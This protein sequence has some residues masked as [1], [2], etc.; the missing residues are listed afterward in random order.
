MATR[1]Y[2]RP[3]IYGVR[4]NLSAWSK[5]VAAR[6][7]SRSVAPGA[8]TGVTARGVVEA[9]VVSWTAPT[10]RADGEDLPFGALAGY[11]VF[12][13]DEPSIDVSDPGTYDSVWFVNAETFTYALDGSSLGPWYFVVCAVDRAGNQGLPSTEV[14]DSGLIGPDDI[15][16]DDWSTGNAEAVIVGAGRIFLKMR[17]AKT[18]WA[19]FSYYKV[20]TDVNTGSGFPGSWSL[21]GTTTTGFMHSPLNTSYAYQYKVT[22]VA[23]DGT[24]TTGT[25]HNGAGSGYIPNEEDQD[26]L[27]ADT[28][29]AQHIIAQ[30]DIKGRTLIG[31]TLRS[32]NWGTSDGTEFNLDGGTFKLGGSS[33]PKL[34]WD[35]SELVTTGTHRSENY[36]EGED[37][38]AIFKNGNAEFYNIYIRGGTIE[39][40][41]IPSLGTV[42]ENVVDN[43]S[44]E[45]VSAGKPANWKTSGDWVVDD[46][47][48]YHGSRSMRCT[49]SGTLHSTWGP[50]N[51]GLDVKG[52]IAVKSDVAPTSPT[53]VGS[54]TGSGTG[55]SVVCVSSANGLFVGVGGS[56]PKLVSFDMRDPTNPTVRSSISLSYT[57]RHIWISGSTLGV[58]AGAELNLYTV[59]TDQTLTLY[60]TLDSRG[61]LFGTDVACGCYFSLFRREDYAIASWGNNGDGQLGD[62][63]TTN[64]SSPTRIGTCTWKAIDGGGYHSLGIRGDNRL[65]SWG[66]NGYGELGDGTYEDRLEPTLIGS[67]T[68]KAISAGDGYSLGIRA[69]DRLLAWGRNDYYQLG[70]GTT[71]YSTSPKLIGSC[72][73]KAVAA[74]SFHSLGIRADDRLLGWGYNESGQIGDGTTNNRTSPTLVGSCTWKSIAVGEYHSLGIRSDDRLLAWGNNYYYQLGDGTT[75]SQASPKL[76]GT[77]TW[78][79]IAAGYYH[80]MGIRGDGRLLAWGENGWGQLG[81]GTT[82]S[83]SSPQIIGSSTWK[84]IAGGGGHSIGIRSDDCIM[85]WGK[86][87][88]GELGDG[89]TIARYYPTLSLANALDPG[90][91]GLHTAILYGNCM[92]NCSDYQIVMRRTEDY[93]I[94]NRITLSGA[95]RPYSVVRS[96]NTLFVAARGSTHLF[97]INISDPLSA[98]ILQTVT[99]AAAATDIVVYGNHLY[100]QTASDVKVY[101]VSDPS[102]ITYVRAFGDASN[103][104][105]GLA[106]YGAYLYTCGVSSGNRVIKVYSLADPSS[107]SYVGTSGNQSNKMA[108]P[109]GYGG[110]LYLT[111]YDGTDL[112]PKGYAATLANAD[113]RLYGQFGTAATIGAATFTGS[114]LND[115]TSGGHYTGLESDPISYRVQIDG[116]GTPDTFKWS[117]DGGASWVATGVNIMG[118]AQHLEDGVVVTF[119]A[120][121]GH[122]VGDRWDFT[123]TPSQVL[124]TVQVYR[125]NRDSPLAVDTWQGAVRV[126]PAGSVSGAAQAMRAVVE[127]NVGASDKVWVDAVSL[128]NEV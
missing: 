87:S 4:S 93:S 121:T 48:A 112:A 67:C 1:G 13:S 114:G 128:R 75:I 117:N 30:Y 118:T 19:G 102:D 72:T 124:D 84:S 47:D 58:I 57:P 86:N 41:S 62:G 39:L 27:L 101:D 36:V 61:A 83:R 99:P 42:H 80:S 71:T 45:R 12:V 123:V 44:F 69:D 16:V 105:Y 97:S 107:P 10:V 3:H 56:A 26:N 20:Y 35:G 33:N 63:T 94:A 40:D 115:M 28:V 77:C 68:W 22:V 49:G 126:L 54:A 66:N 89:T 127:S 37:G 52:G 11:R 5:P 106:L 74:G 125:G 7:P 113:I 17:A 18:T 65:L 98:S 78:K 59:N 50:C 32:T 116:T 29:A 119:G 95:M 38:W 109:D 21:I 2:I 100:L 25:V 34:A 73:W 76:I 79:A 43:F 81:D 70:D 120:T 60:D 64:R 108:Y 111:D 23:R 15:Q 8:P 9:V 92:Y 104:T 55:T 96:G 103:G 122:T 24:E 31:G 14:S 91:I 90:A 85:A 51:A 110:K 53:I 82:T 46:A 88:A 6:L